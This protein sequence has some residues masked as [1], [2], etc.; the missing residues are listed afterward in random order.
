MFLAWSIPAA[1][2]IGSIPFGLLIA[3][4]RGIDIRKHGSG[5]IGATNVGRV[6]GKKL[7]FFCFACDL[8]KGLAPTLG[9]GLYLGHAGRW[10]VEPELAWQWLAVMA[11]PV[12]GHMFCPWIGFK[13]GKGVATGLGALLGVFPALTIPG[14]GAAVVW[15]VM[16]WV[17][18]YV[19]MSSVVA[20]ASLP[21]W[22]AGEFVAARAA[23][24]IPGSS[25][26][27]DIARLA[28]PFFALTLALAALV[29]VKHRANIARTL[30]GTEPKV[31]WLGGPPRQTPPRA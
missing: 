4:S 30:A 24:W 1:F 23:G 15:L 5:N 18:R 19:G 9:A 25:A 27:M 29:I 6:L 2:L 8:L 13:G 3:R 26:W 17:W 11:S 7:G 14:I 28:V 31:K 21:V 22:V 16:L 12:V 10:S 20:A